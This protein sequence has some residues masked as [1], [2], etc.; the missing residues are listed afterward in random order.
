MCVCVSPGELWESEQREPQG[1]KVHGVDRLQPGLRVRP[2]RQL[3]GRVRPA[4]RGAG[5]HAERPL[6]Q[7][8]LL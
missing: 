2:V 3:G 5:G 6:Q 1:V 7:R 4:Q 8:G